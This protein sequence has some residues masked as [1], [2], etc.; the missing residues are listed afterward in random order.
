MTG[1]EESGP[2]FF[3]PTRIQVAW[4]FQESKEAEEVQRLKDIVDK[5]AATQEKKREKAEATAQRQIVQANVRDDRAAQRQL[6]QDAKQAA[7]ELRHLQKAT[8]KTQEKPKK[9]LHQRRT[10]TKIFNDQDPPAEREVVIT[11]SSRTRTCV[12]PKRYKK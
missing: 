9:A 5:R 7:A 6:T 1:K 4:D 12:R 2:Q 8:K 10:H 11:G 3:S